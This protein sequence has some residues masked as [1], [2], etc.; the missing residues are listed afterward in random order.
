VAGRDSEE[1][2]F[3][4]FDINSQFASGYAGPRQGTRVMTV[5]GLSSSNRE[6]FNKSTGCFIESSPSS[7]QTLVH[8]DARINKKQ[9]LMTT[10]PKI[11]NKSKTR[12]AT[13]L[14]FEPAVEGSPADADECSPT[15]SQYLT[16]F[17]S[18]VIK[19][20]R[21]SPEQT[22]TDRQALK[23]LALLSE[24]KK[25]FEWYVDRLGHPSHLTAIRGKEVLT[26]AVHAGI[27]PEV[28]VAAGNRFGLKLDIAAFSSSDSWLAWVPALWLTITPLTHLTC[29]DTICVP[30][31]QHP[32]D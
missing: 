17:K 12:P 21:K 2:D 16:R 13:P 22:D 32:G 24:K 31:G 5:T 7:I 14:Q 1:E 4:D 18:H 10:P 9:K 23:T 3:V 25:A 20:R 26:R 8:K 28:I 6:R 27:T 11:E 29:S 15:A 19:R 30:V